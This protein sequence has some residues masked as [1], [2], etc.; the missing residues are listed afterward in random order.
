MRVRVLAFCI[1]GLVKT[2]WLGFLLLTG[3]AAASPSQ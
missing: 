2:V 1:N 3:A